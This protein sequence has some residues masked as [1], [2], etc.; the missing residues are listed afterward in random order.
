[1]E[2]NTNTP[3]STE[4]GHQS[5]RI[6]GEQNHSDSLGENQ[7]REIPKMLQSVLQNCNQST[8]KENCPDSGLESNANT[9]RSTEKGQQSASLATRKEHGSDWLQ[10][11]IEKLKKQQPKEKKG[12][13][14]TS[15]KRKH[16]AISKLPK[17]LMGG[18]NQ[19]QQTST[20]KI[21]KIASE[22]TKEQKPTSEQVTVRFKWIGEAEG[23]TTINAD[24]HEPII[25]ALKKSVHFRIKYKNLKK[26]KN[27][28]LIIFGNHLKAII[29]PTVSCGALGKEET[30]DL[31]RKFLKKNDIKVPETPA[32]PKRSGGLFF[33]VNKNGQTDGGAVR[34]VLHYNKQ[35]SDHN[36][37]LAV[38]GYG[39]ETI[40]EALKNDKRF[41]D[42]NVL[43]LIGTKLDKYERTMTLSNLMENDTYT[44]IILDNIE[45][46]DEHTNEGPHEEATESDPIL[47]T[48]RAS[49]TPG[50]FSP[51]EAM[52]ERFKN[53]FN[54][55]V[56]K[57][58]GLKKTW[59]LIKQDFSINVRKPPLT[60]STMRKLTKHM[61][62]VAQIKVSNEEGTCFLLTRDLFLTC[63]HVVKGLLY[64]NRPY[65]A[66]IIFHYEDENQ[67][68]NNQ[69]NVFSINILSHSEEQDYAIFSAEIC[70]N[71]EGVL[72]YPEGLLQYLALPPENGAVSIIGHPGGRCKHTDLCSVI[73]FFQR[74]EVIKETIFHDPSF[75][76]VLRLYN[77]LEM[78][79]PS[80]VTY[81]T[82]LYHGASGSPVFDE[83]GQLVAMHS[84][85]YI[86]D[87]PLEKKSV[88]EYGRSIIDILI[89]GAVKIEDLCL[90]LKEMAKQNSSLCDYISQGLHPVLMQS[91]IRRLL[92][93]WN[94]EQ[95]PDFDDSGVGDSPMDI[96]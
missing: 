5:T 7:V 81:N 89:Y 78:E 34:I 24:P 91:I 35:G 69:E 53:N 73:N 94:V 39:D 68:V 77:F 65:I 55:Y 50:E 54:M 9:P 83:H 52:V 28:N 95:N 87:A 58:K 33:K 46:V 31:K 66:R 84:G 32:Y 60:A 38:F 85:G 14:T 2:S 90:R 70:S 79:D 64:T 88:I 8:D 63:H 23:Y 59:R 47:S 62:S 3:R 71:Q 86:V 16:S 56:K 15:G 96:S 30:L 61:D 4:E 13:R 51:K 45:T 75:V 67:I 21:P 37:P 93:L 42:I 72:Q 11:Y 12:P 92:N 80:L 48:N 10:K 44:I 29:N 40:E 74:K 19:R 36:T 82:C 26:P 20:E 41:K 1:M 27:S 6:L 17:F 49:D 76:H 22:S 25:G 18:E 57:N 43:R